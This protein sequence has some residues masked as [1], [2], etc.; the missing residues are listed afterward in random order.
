MT[1]RHVHSP[2]QLS[3]LL[4]TTRKARK[5]TQGELASRM[6]LSANRFSEL[7]SDLG[8]LTVDRLFELVHALGLE[9]IVQNAG[10]PASP[11]ADSAKA[12]W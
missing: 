8:G 5:L 9:I 4:K 3:V 2:A 7:E 12:P 11:A 10:E 6:G 1:Q